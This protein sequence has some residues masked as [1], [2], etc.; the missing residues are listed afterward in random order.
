MQIEIDLHAFKVLTLLLDSESD[1]YDGVIHRLLREQHN[2]WTL[3][4]ALPPIGPT[5][6][7]LMTPNP[8]FHAAKGRNN[9]DVG[10]WIGNVF[11]PDGPRFRATYKGRTYLATIT[12]D[13]WIDEDGT[14]RQSPSEAA[15]AISRANVNR[16]RFWYGQRP[17]D[18]VW[19]RLDEFRK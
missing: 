18:N 7:A 16:W 3:S 11:F 19:H 4:E 2:D 15:S 12:K 10:V 17:K 5:G 1:S 8:G 6:D 14:E 9:P 13:C